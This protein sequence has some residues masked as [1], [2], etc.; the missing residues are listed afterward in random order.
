[1]SIRDRLEHAL[2]GDVLVVAPLEESA[3]VLKRHQSEA[4]APGVFG[5]KGAV[6]QLIRCRES[7]DFSLGSRLHVDFV[8]AL[9]VA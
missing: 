3:L 8:D 1:M 7:G 6:P 4:V 9:P 2:D 5:R